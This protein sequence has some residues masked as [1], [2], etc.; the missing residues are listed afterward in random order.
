M[1][2]FGELIPDGGD[3]AGRVHV[4]DAPFPSDPRA[5]IDT[6]TD[7][8]GISSRSRLQ[9]IVFTNCTPYQQPS[10]LILILT[11]ISAMGGPWRLA[12]NAALNLSTTAKLVSNC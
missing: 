7:E 6:A 11:P 1:H 12:D 9:P 5:N 3:F 2:G 10:W 8:L 4:P